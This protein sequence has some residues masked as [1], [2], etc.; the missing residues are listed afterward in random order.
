VVGTIAFL[1]VGN[2]QGALRKMFVKA[3]W[4]GA[5][6]GVAHRLLDTLLRWC[7][8]HAIDKVYL[9]T[10]AKFLAAHRFYEKNGFVEI[11]RSDL[12]RAFPV[13]EVDTKFYK[14]ALQ[15]TRR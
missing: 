15:P 6:H 11:A 12:P 10:T 7:R 1:D 8:D 3:A 9:G 5:A 2:R 14:A 13:M 4:R